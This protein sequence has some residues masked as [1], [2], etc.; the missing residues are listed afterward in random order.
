[1]NRAVILARGLGSR[2]RCS[3]SS[4]SLD[5]DQ[6]AA[7]GEGLK[8][9]IPIGRPFLDYLL[10]SLADA[11]YDEACLVI[12]PEHHSV[13]K[14]YEAPGRLSRIG[15]SF[16]V[17][18]EPRGTADAVRAAEYFAGGQR[19]LVCN[20]DNYYPASVLA[21][22]RALTGPGLAGFAP[23][24]LVGLSNIPA[25]RV[26][27][28]ALLSENRDGY[29]ADIVEKP[30]AATA[31]R[32]GPRARVSMNAWVFEPDIFEACRHVT[33]SVRGELELQDAVRY[34]MRALGTRFRVVPVEAGVLDLSNRGDI[35]TVAE[36][37]TGIEV[38]L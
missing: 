1:M 36:H 6:E 28:F 23:G 13:R 15:V 31:A 19:F 16:A 4:A 24:A 32:L 12:G 5:A 29:L 34:A 17:Q 37:L 27:Q 38:R 21:A 10:S 8:G 11:G 35:A 33:P 30:D 25:S 3:D 26:A 20:A 7:A 18:E 22:L 14:Y 2:M 9:M